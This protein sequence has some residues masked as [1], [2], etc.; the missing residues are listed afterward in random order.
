AHIDGLPVDRKV[1]VRADP[2]QQIARLSGCFG[3]FEA[4]ACGRTAR[5]HGRQE[6]NE[7]RGGQ[8][9]HRAAPTPHVSESTTLAVVAQASAEARLSAPRP[10][11]VPRNAMG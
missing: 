3:G 2:Y 1:A 5:Q 9:A 10:P 4:V 8:S 7:D 11:Y 6:K